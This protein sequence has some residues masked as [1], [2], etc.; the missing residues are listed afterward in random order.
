MW[1]VNITVP[2][3]NSESRDDPPNYRGMLLINAVYK[4]FSN[5]VNSRLLKWANAFGKIC[6][7]QSGF[8]QG[9]SAV[10]H[11]FYNN[12]NVSI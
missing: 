2:V 12:N 5:F 8:R 4:I 10:N 6:D 1:K 9:Y 3:C 11:M 7:V